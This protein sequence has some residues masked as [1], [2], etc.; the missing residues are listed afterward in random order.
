MANIPLGPQHQTRA[1][2]LATKTLQAF[3]DAVA[4]DG[5]NAYRG[6]L[7]RV[8]PHMADAYRQEANPFRSHMGASSIGRKCAREIWYSFR[9]ATKPKF[10]GRMLRLFNRGHLEEGRILALL[11]LIGCTVYQQDANGNQYRISAHGGHYGGSGDGVFVGCPDLPPDLPALSEFKTHNDKSFQAIKVQGLKAGKPEHYA[12]MQQYMRHMKLTVG[13][14]FAVN[15]NDDEIYAEI[16][17]LDSEDADRYTHRAIQIIS[18][19][20][21][22]PER[23]ANTSAA[24]D[25]KFCDHRP[26]CHLGVAPE[27]NCR[28]CTFSEAREDGTWWCEHPDRQMNMLFGPKEGVSVVGE[29]FQLSKERQL[30]G[31]SMWSKNMKAFR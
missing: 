17:Q 13:V 8:L 14:Y 22:P 28:T 30:S 16:I 26:V 6:W 18:A 12:Q 29:T 10:S 5:G 31:C 23:I 11:L 1:V 9:W 15:K 3:E 24:F 7:Q 2:V 27:V 20:T 25:C 19:G 4:V 21:T